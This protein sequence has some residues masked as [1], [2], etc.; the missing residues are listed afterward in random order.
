MIE[1]V[2]DIYGQKKVPEPTSIVALLAL[3]FGGSSILK[4]QDQ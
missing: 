4:R 3:A 1:I 2:K